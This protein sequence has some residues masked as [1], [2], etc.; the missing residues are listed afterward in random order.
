MSR[1]E[2]ITFNGIPVNPADVSFYETMSDDG[3]GRARLHMF[4]PIPGLEPTR[5][6][7]SRSADVKYPIG[8]QIFLYEGNV[9]I[10]NRNA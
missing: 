7:V 5:V 4:F 3:T 1:R 6:Y 10:P 8:P 9:D 2:A